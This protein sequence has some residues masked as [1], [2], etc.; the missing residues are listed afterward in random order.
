VTEPPAD[1]QRPPWAQLIRA[2]R[3]A[4]YPQVTMRQAAAAADVSPSTWTEIENGAKSVAPGVKVAVRGTPDKIAK[5]ARFL[6]ISA[7]DLRE[8]GRPDAATHLERLLGLSE[9]HLSDRQ[10]RMLGRK[11]DDDAPE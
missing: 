8:A 3:E 5:M 4:L 6:E 10:K 11:V 7:A 1:A 9:R 2:R